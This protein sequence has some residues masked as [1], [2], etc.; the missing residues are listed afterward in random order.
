[1]DARVVADDV[2]VGVRVAVAEHRPSVGV[3]ATPART[4]RLHAEGIAQ[5]LRDVPHARV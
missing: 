2:E 3:I 1:V 5:F 4:G